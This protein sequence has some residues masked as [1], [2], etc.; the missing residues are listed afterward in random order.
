M[1]PTLSEAERF[2]LLSPAGRTL[3]HAMREHPQAPIWNWP[4][5]EQLNGAGLQRVRQFASELEEAQV[6]A[7][8]KQ[9]AWL[10]EFV[11]FCVEEVPFYRRR[12]SP[13]AALSAVPSCS[14]EDLSTKV[15]DFV[16]DSQPLDELIVFS[17]SGTTG[18]PTRTPTH[19]ATAA[20]GIPLIEA[21]LA[22][23]AVQ[24]PRSAD[25]MALSN[26]VAYRG[27]YTTAIVI[28]YLQ[29]AGCIRVN[30][31]PEVWRQPRDCAQYLDRF[32]APV[33]L[34]DPQAFAALESVAIERPPQV[35]VSSILHMPDAF[36]ARLTA[37]YGCPVV[38]LYALTEAGIV[39]VKTPHGHQI[40]PHD[41]YVEILDEHD[42]PCPT[43]VRGEV[44]LTGGQNP[45]LPLLRY[46]TGDYASLAWHAGQPTLVGLEGRQPVCFPTPNGV[47][48]S[49]EVT[50]L[51]R[52][53][54]V[55]QY[56]LHQD[57]AGGFTFRYRGFVDESELQAAL[58]ELL[59]KPARLDITAL[60]PSD[61]AR[62]KLLVYRSDHP[63]AT[64]LT[65]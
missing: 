9:P 53:H 57:S 36:A 44:T 58:F 48:H 20:C 6:L 21:A 56:Q 23:A 5:G 60:P 35:F 45:F 29:E 27:A 39:A 64:T 47:V 31:S 16:P 1:Y 3:L 15:W 11:T 63:A 59:G 4:N 19:P 62:R 46:R 8:D 37:R 54:P 18:F 24:F 41:L 22:G 49:M 28:S 61:K 10:T 13:G 52:Q 55:V 34:G 42:V 26:I 17:S 32:W 25:Q 33:M 43:G 12:S 40:L 14:R 65:L 38:D 50:R 51:M 7:A 2:P 30:L